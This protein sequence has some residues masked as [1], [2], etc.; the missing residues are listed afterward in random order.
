[1][2]NRNHAELAALL[3]R[4][5]GVGAGV[6]KGVG[7]RDVWR[8]IATTDRLAAGREELRKAIAEI[9]ETAV[10]NDWVDADK[11][12][13]WLKKLKRGRVLNEGWPKYEVG[14]V[15]SNALRVKFGSTNPDSIQ[16]EAQLLREMGLEEGRHFTVKMPEGDEKGYVSILRKGLE[17]AAWLSVHG[18]GEQQRLV[19]DFVEYILQRAW[20]AGKEVYE[21]VREVIEE[22]KARGSL[23]LKGL[24]KKAEVNGREH[25]VKVI[26][27]GAE[28]DKGRGCKKLLKIKITAEVDGV[29]SEYEVTYG[30]YGRTNAA[31]GRA[32]AS[33]YAPGGREADAERFAVLIKA[34]TGREPKMYQKSDGTIE[35]MCYEGHLNGLRRYAELADTI[36]RWLGETR[37]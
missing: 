11:A 32:Y 20:E 9:V 4:H 26:D 24:E 28:F 19:A 37:R 18:S 16:R 33:I 7:K 15:R 6:K 27:G 14:L 12:E 34:L 17:R 29:R 30:R 1:L 10:K 21:K 22:G 2:S 8:V 25:M 23:T 31:V 36:E 5:A 3:L 13:R 35:A